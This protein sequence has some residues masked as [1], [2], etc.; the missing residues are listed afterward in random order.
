MTFCC[1]FHEHNINCNFIKNIQNEL[2]NEDNKEKYTLDELKETLPHFC[3]LK[4]RCAHGISPKCDFPDDFC[5]HVY[6]CLTYLN[7]KDKVLVEKR[8]KTTKSK[9]NIYSTCCC[10]DKKINKEDN[11]IH[12]INTIFRAKYFNSESINDKNSIIKINIQKNYIPQYEKMIFLVGKNKNILE[13]ME[14]LNSDKQYLNIYGDTIEDLKIFINVLIEYYQE[15]NEEKKNKHIILDEFNIQNFKDELKY[16]I[17]YFFYIQDPNY[18]QIIE[19]LKTKYKIILFSEK[20]ID[21][22][23]KRIKINPKPLESVNNNIYIPNYYVKYQ[24]KYSAREIW[25]ND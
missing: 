20:P 19:D 1:C 25:N 22:G 11:I 24:D 5:Y 18:I 4:P 13:V 15:R 12:N 23:F 2:Y 8:G 9:E 17:K 3:H 16:N 7:I 14:I 10:Y 21:K 6:F